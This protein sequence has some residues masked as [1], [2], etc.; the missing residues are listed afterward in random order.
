MCRYQCEN[1]INNSQDKMSPIELS[2]ITTVGK[3]LKITFMDMI[4]AFKDEIN[5]SIKGIYKNTKK[6]NE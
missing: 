1:T 5:K 2:N 4:E 3:D 6:G